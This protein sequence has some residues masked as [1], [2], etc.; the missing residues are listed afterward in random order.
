GAGARAGLIA[1]LLFAV[2]PVHVEAVAN[3]V[4]R[5]ELMAAL[6]TLLAVY[7]AVVRESPAWSGVALACGLLSKENAAVAPALVAS[8]WLL[9]VGVTRPPRRTMVALAAAWAAAR[10][11]GRGV[12]A[13][14]GRGGA[15]P[16]G[17]SVVPGRRPRR[18]ADPLPALRRVRRGGWGVARRVA[19]PAG[20]GPRWPG[21]LGRRRAHRVARAGLAGRY[22][23]DRQHPGGL[24]ALLSRAAIR[25]RAAAGRAESCPGAGVLPRGAR[26]LRPG[27]APLHRGRRRGAGAR[28]AGPRGHAA[29]PGGGSVRSLFR[30][31]SEPGRGRARARRL[32]HRRFAPG[33]RRQDGVAMRRFAATLAGLGAIAGL[34]A[35]HLALARRGGGYTG[36]LLILDHLFSITLVLGMVAIAAGVGGRLLKA[37]GLR[38]ERSLEA[39]L[40]GTVVG[41]GT[42]A[43]A[44]FVV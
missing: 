24:T 20:A 12:R 1:G 41:L 26:A 27:L 35:A 9:G 18:R 15:R 40:F 8:A 36:V 32:E 34:V 13:G 25:R 5:G 7:A 30:E 22:H 2:H 17:Q 23:G 28:S 19:R 29:A 3:V 38:L 14:V 44:I 4:G 39:L 21:P 37:G 31:L 6:W 16:R 43:T 33:A 11:P 10:R 42:L